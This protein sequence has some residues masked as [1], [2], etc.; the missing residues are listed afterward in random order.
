MPFLSLTMIRRSVATA[1]FLLPGLL[2]AETVTM[3]D[4]RVLHGRIVNQSSEEIRLQVG[5]RLLRID[6]QDIQRIEYH[7]EAGPRKSEDSGERKQPAARK[8]VLKKQR[9][10]HRPDQRKKAED[11]G[12]RPPA[13]EW[14]VQFFRIEGHRRSI[15][16]AA[17]QDFLNSYQLFGRFYSLTKWNPYA[18]G[19]QI[20]G[21][22]QRGLWRYSVGLGLRSLDADQNMIRIEDNSLSI[23]GDSGSFRPAVTFLSG[24]GEH[25]TISFRAERS[26]YRSI[27]SEIGLRLTAELQTENV[28][29]RGHDILAHL[30][31]VDGLTEEEVMDP[32]RYMSKDRRYGLDVVYYRPWQGGRLAFSAGILTGTA[33]T[34]IKSDRA[35]I[36]TT[37]TPSASR[38]IGFTV[39][40]GE[41][42]GRYRG[43]AFSVEYFRP[44]FRRLEWGIRASR[45][46]ARYETLSRDGFASGMY[47]RENGLESGLVPMGLN[48]PTY[49]PEPRLFILASEL[50]IGIRYRM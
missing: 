17:V 45:Q 6:K 9:P 38:I 34:D 12:R 22:L 8:P 47:M 19:Y 13:S 35:T 10:A 20:E 21:T 32:T 42:L 41:F 39:Y 50:W 24:Q 46:R 25:R 5:D 26:L 33:T 27:D 40:D 31:T 3:K 37:L 44:L 49:M 23:S 18:P 43:L 7:D 1:L 2:L 36:E 29:Y 28:T 16:E 14:Y 30:D 11:S 48:L 15:T 4:G